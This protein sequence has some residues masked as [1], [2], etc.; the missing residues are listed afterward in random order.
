MIRDQLLL[1][2]STTN[3]KDRK[4]VEA[5]RKLILNRIR[6]EKNKIEIDKNKKN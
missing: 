2:F 5:K 4:E 6:G 1:I 3:H